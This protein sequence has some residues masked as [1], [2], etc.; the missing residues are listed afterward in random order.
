M[1]FATSILPL[2]LLICGLFV[3]S[4]RAQDDFRARDNAVNELERQL[5]GLTKQLED[6]ELKREQ[7][8]DRLSHVDEEERLEVLRLETG[9]L[10]IEKE[11]NAVR[12]QSVVVQQQI[13]FHANERHNSPGHSRLDESRRR[14]EHIQIAHDHLREAGLNDLADEVTKQ[15]EQLQRRIQD[16][17]TPDSNDW[18]HRKMADDE[19]R[20]EV[21]GA[22][23]E[24][25]AAVR[26]LREE[27]GRLRNEMDRK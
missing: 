5:H 25:N 2:T 9:I 22:I 21:I 19:F 20:A 10:E 14:L 15:G 4:S 18:R 27:I 17:E 13:E 3:S 11:M 6:L 1:K 24:L 8:F 12:S 23:R 26:S 16:A 7:L